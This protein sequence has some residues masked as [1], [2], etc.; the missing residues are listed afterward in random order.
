M[1]QRTALVAA[2]APLPTPWPVGVPEPRIFSCG[3]METPVWN[4]ITRAWELTAVGPEFFAP[5]RVESLE[6]I[7]AALTCDH[8]SK[9]VK[10]TVRQLLK[11]QAA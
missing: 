8:C 7:A 10:A 5:N 9:A 6:D 2:P 1:S 11:G 3:D 4:P